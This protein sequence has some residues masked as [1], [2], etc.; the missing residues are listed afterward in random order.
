MSFSSSAAGAAPADP[1]SSADGG[2][3]TGT[4]GHRRRRRE[5][6]LP[7]ATLALTAVVGL[8]VAGL[9]LG[10]TGRLSPG[11]PPPALA[12]PTLSVTAPTLRA[13]GQDYSA[14][15][16]GAAVPALLAPPTAG[17]LLAPSTAAGSAATESGEPPPAALDVA[18]HRLWAPA[19]QRA[20]LAAVSGEPTAAA[21][22]LDYARYDG[23]PA[24]VIV[25]A[26]RGS[27]G[28]RDIYVVGP[29]CGPADVD[30][31][32]FLRVAPAQ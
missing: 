1:A 26:G 12:R 25:L 15:T 10:A 6:R 27:T 3:D 2:A 18:L 21:L 28:R 16:L 7:W 11:R 31:R 13:S 8:L 4:A 30:L 22:A 17:G 23:Q 9:T 29:G 24:L 5:R 14:T 19:A 32:S 20:C